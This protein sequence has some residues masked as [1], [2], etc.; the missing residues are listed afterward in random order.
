METKPLLPVLENV[1]ITD[2]AENGLGVG[3]VDNM[4]VF[5]EG[6]VPGDVADVQVFRKKKKFLEGRLVRLIESS[7]DRTDL[8]VPTLVPAGVAN[9]ST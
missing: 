2:T 9:G 8:F 3:R 4:V 1:N 6:A 5:V 7:P